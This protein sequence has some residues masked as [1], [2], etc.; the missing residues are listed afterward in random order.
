LNREK[1]DKKRHVTPGPPPALRQWYWTSGSTGYRGKLGRGEKLTRFRGNAE[2]DEDKGQI[3]SNI[4]GLGGGVKPNPSKKGV[5][6]V[7]T[8]GGTAK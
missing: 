1:T 5:K 8:G 6:S 7:S 2:V 3:K 4:H